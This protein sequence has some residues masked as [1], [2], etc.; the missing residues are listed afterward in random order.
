MIHGMR[1]LVVL[2][3][4]AVGEAVGKGQPNSAKW[5]GKKVCK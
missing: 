1:M 2:N 4:T 5:E 3:C